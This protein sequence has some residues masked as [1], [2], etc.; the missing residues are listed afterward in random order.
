MHLITIHLEIFREQV[1]KEIPPPTVQIERALPLAMAVTPGHTPDAM[2]VNHAGKYPP[3]KCF[4]C[5]KI[6]HVSRFCPEKTYSK[7][8][9]NAEEEDEEH[10]VSEAS[11]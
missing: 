6:G 3:I 7:E 11:Q 1:W 8:I 5:G 2:D 10:N 9:P 4:Y